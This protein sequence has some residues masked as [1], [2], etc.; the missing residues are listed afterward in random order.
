VQI[1]PCCHRRDAE[2]RLDLRD[3]DRPGR[4]QQIRDQP[5]PIL[6]DRVIRR[7]GVGMG[8]IFGRVGFCAVGDQPAEARAAILAGTV[9]AAP[10]GPPTRFN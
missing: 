1:A 5:A 4:E 10:A 9:S 8:G 3:G 2:G 6:R 7:G